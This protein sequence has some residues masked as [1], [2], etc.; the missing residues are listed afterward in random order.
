MPN[1]ETADKIDTGQGRM[2][3]FFRQKAGSDCAGVASAFTSEQRR[4]GV[5]FCGEEEQGSGA[6]GFF[7]AKGKKETGAERTLR[8]RGLQ[9]GLNTKFNDF[10][11]LS[12]RAAPN[13]PQPCEFD[14]RGSVEKINRFNT[15]FNKAASPGFPKRHRPHPARPPHPGSHCRPAPARRRPA[16]FERPR[17]GQATRP[18]AAQ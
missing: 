8:R 7:S 16:V 9:P 14:M 12:I 4:R 10:R 18:A 5:T 13:L 6:D 15:L 1:R 17:A 11:A 3:C 2:P